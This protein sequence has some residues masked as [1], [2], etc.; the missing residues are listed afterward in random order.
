MANILRWIEEPLDRQLL[1]EAQAI[2][3]PVKNMLW[4]VG[5]PENSDNYEAGL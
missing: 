3:Q 1:A 5:R 4:P 2:L